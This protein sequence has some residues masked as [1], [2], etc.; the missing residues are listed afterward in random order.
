MFSQLE[1]ESNSG[2]G[3]HEVILAGTMQQRYTR[4]EAL[5]SSVKVL[6]NHNGI[7]LF[8][9][10]SLRHKDISQNA[11]ALLIFVISFNTITLLIYFKMT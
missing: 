11:Y 3:E 4:E 8:L 10:T 6:D 9:N 7:V 2:T 1:V 5:I